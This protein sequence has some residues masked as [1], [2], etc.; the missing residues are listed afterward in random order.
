MTGDHLPSGSWDVDPRGSTITWSVKHLGVST[1]HGSFGEFRGLIADGHATGTV[2][3][4]SVQS[5]DEK[6]DRFVC[7]EEFLGAEAFPELRFAGDAPPGEAASLAGELTIRGTTLPLTLHVAGSEPAGDQVR[8]R[9][10]CKIPRRAY[11]LR[12]PQAMGSA[13]RTVSDEVEVVLDLT[14]VPA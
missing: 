6:R 9:L 12:F 2:V 11:G 3:A 8:L 5:D 14:L 4:A 13:D 7:S 10:T 1:V